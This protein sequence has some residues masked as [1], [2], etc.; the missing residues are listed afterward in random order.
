MNLYGKII[1]HKEFKDV[2]FE[3][4]KSFDVGHKVKL[5]GEWINMGFVKSYHIGVRQNLV[6]LKEDYSNWLYC[7]NSQ[8]ECLRNAEWKPIQ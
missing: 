5:N 1:K 6:I 2:C 8:I 4:R 3:V 7:V